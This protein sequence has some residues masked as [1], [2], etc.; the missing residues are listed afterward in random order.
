MTQIQTT[1]AN[2]SECDITMAVY[3]LRSLLYGCTSFFDLVDAF[4]EAFQTFA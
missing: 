4:F 2:F 1:P 3:K